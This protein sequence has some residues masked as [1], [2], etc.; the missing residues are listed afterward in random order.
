MHQIALSTSSL[1]YYM[2]PEKIGWNSL[3]GYSPLSTEHTR[4]CYANLYYRSKSYHP[5]CLRLRFLLKASAYGLHI[6]RYR[7]LIPLFTPTRV[8]QI[9]GAWYPFSS[10]LF[11]RNHSTV[12][13]ALGTRLL[14]EQVRDDQ[15]D[16]TPPQT[17]F[18]DIAG[19][20]LIQRFPRSATWPYGKPPEE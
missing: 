7:S 9:N 8:F 4:T 18:R 15:P 13:V 5:R 3:Q 6:S 12:P 17:S 16:N 2:T 10:T 14:Q 11:F 1:T 19:S 20:Q